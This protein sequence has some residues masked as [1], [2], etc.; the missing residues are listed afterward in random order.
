MKKLP[1]EI[2]RH[3][4]KDLP[5]S[6]LK[7]LRLCWP[8]LEPFIL[9]RLFHT[10]KVN[11]AEKHI[12]KL[13]GISLSPHIAPL[14]QQ[15]IWITSGT[16]D[17]HD[18]P[19]GHVNAWTGHE[20]YIKEFRGHFFLSIDAMPNLHTFASE[21]GPLGLHP[22]RDQIDGLVYALWPA[23]RRR[24]SRI[25]SFRCQDPLNY[26]RWLNYEC[27]QAMGGQHT[28]L[29][30][31]FPAG[32]LRGTVDSLF[33]EDLGL[34]TPISRREFLKGL[35]MTQFPMVGLDSTS[36]MVWR[37]PLRKLRGLD[38]R[39][40]SAGGHWKGTSSSE[41]MLKFF[42]MEANNIRE[43]SLR[44]RPTGTYSR[45]SSHSKWVLQ[46]VLCC[47]WK[48]LQTIRISFAMLPT[49][50]PFVEFMEG[51]TETLKHILIHGCTGG[52][53]SPAEIIKAAAEAEKLKLHRFLVLPSQEGYLQDIVEP[54]IIP[55]RLVLDFVNKKDPSLDPFKEYLPGRDCVWGTVTQKAASISEEWPKDDGMHFT[56]RQCTNQV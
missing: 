16:R 10:I 14:V 49:S 48:F 40:D 30:A 34:P 22:E 21:L 6:S 29:P 1:P 54:W 32:P 43:L 45:P 3:I 50:K 51:H 17:T 26:M 15:L 25:T 5:P 36:T 8:F 4:L 56:C 53:K 38:L 18:D 28:E 41:G 13:Q 9:P 47:R 35:I 39:I 11:F 2:I 44:F 31:S 20:D 7:V 19:H 33:S 52:N 27:L 12:K 42:L 55:E 23:M 37:W 46:G 24:K